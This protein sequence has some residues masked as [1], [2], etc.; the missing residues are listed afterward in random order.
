[1]SLDCWS[2]FSHICIY[3]Y[4]CEHLLVFRAW[5][6]LVTAWARACIK[7]RTRIADMTLRFWSNCQHGLTEKCVMGDLNKGTRVITSAFA[8][9]LLACHLIVDQT[10]DTWMDLFAMGGLNK[11]HESAS[12]FA[13]ALL[14]CRLT[15]KG[16]S[17]FSHGL[18]AS[19]HQN[20][21]A[22]CLHDTWFLVKLSSR[23]SMY[24][25]TYICKYTQMCA[26]LYIYKLSRTCWWHHVVECH[27][28][29]PTVS[30][31][32]LVALTH[33]DLVVHESNDIPP[34]ATNKKTDECEW[35]RGG[36]NIQEN[37]LIKNH[38]TSTWIVLHVHIP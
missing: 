25:Y 22:H 37:R 35:A 5:C 7:I 28:I 8:L 30:E 17:Y 10:L 4:V 16:S 19:V 18:G 9:A 6:P 12:T 27:Q 23:F 33:H 15:K 34:A 20:S 2:N 24:I 31:A 13:R 29:H 32:C 1:M 14:T 3:T 11:G 21:H 26:V 38:T 36:D